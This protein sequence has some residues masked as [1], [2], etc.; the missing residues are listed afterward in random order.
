MTHAIAHV[1]ACGA[2]VSSDTHDLA[3]GAH[4]DS[5]GSVTSA[6]EVVTSRVKRPTWAQ[7]SRRRPLRNVCYRGLEKCR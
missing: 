7:G 4:R 5:L 1:A 2:H 6:S 3:I